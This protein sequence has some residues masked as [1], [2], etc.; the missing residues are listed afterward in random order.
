MPQQLQQF[1][2][3]GLDSRGLPSRA[4]PSPARVVGI[5]NWTV[6]IPAIVIDESD[7]S[8]SS[9]PL[10]VIA[11]RSVSGRGYVSPPASPS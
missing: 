6:R 11:H 7:R 1:G 4:L 2:A 9:I 3:L 8:R 10:I 5:V